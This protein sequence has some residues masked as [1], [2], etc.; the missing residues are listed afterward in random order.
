MQDTA[1]GRWLLGGREAT[2]RHA[3]V[4]WQLAACKKNSWEKSQ[5]LSQNAL[6]KH[7]LCLLLRVFKLPSAGGWLGAARNG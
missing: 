3:G 2:T 7:L 5:P 1:Q 6:F 4:P